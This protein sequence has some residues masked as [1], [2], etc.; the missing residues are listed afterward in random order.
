V[1]SSHGT[2]ARRRPNTFRGRGGCDGGVR[3]SVA[4]GAVGRQRP[5]SV[6]AKQREFEAKRVRMQS[7][8][9]VS[10][11]VKT[12]GPPVSRAE[13][14]NSVGCSCGESRIVSRE[15]ARYGCRSIVQVAEVGRTHRAS[16]PPDVRK[17]MWWE[18]QDASRR[19][20]RG[21]AD[22][23]HEPRKGETVRGRAL[24]IKR[25]RSSGL[26]V[27]ARRLSIRRKVF[28]GFCP[29]YPHRSGDA[30]SFGSQVNLRLTPPGASRT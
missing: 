22:A 20:A 13:L 26:W 8:E 9:A 10:G 27:S 18:E 29:S 15:R 3:G 14:K 12:P 11:V 28:S 16:C 5:R 25:T 7:A 2:G 30:G 17:G 1:A 19:E 24:T 6:H 23:G 4:S 21:T